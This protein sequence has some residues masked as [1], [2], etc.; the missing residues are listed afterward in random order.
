MQTKTM[1]NDAASGKRALQAA[2]EMYAP[3]LALGKVTLSPSK[4]AV[5]LFFYDNEPGLE[6]VSA[7]GKQ[8]LKASFVGA[9]KL[10]DTAAHKVLQDGK[11]HREKQELLETQFSSGML[12][13]TQ[14]LSAMLSQRKP[15]AGRQQAEDCLHEYAAGVNQVLSKKIKVGGRILSDIVDE[16]CNP[17]GAFYEDAD[18]EDNAS[19]VEAQTDQSETSEAS[20]R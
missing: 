3:T 9:Q 19:V 18:E 5:K 4:K 1:F 14:H 11:R 13:I 17:D 8:F 12:C 15:S 10:D 6:D 7:F 20:Q 16:K 2:W